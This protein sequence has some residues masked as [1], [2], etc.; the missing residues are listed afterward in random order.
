MLMAISLA[1]EGEQRFQEDT[2]GQNYLQR[3][4][5]LPNPREGTPW[6][7][8]YA[9]GNDEAFIT[10]TGLDV[11]TFHFLLEPFER[12][13]NSQPLPQCDVPSEAVSRPDRRSLS[14]AGALGLV[15]H[16]LCSTTEDRLLQQI[17]AVTRTVCSRYIR[18]GLESSP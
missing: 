1:L 11:A 14:A 6:E 15:L 3:G 17:F 10:T 13:W 5:L 16:H 18:F 12:K 8:M 2:R 7:A 9:A 4:E